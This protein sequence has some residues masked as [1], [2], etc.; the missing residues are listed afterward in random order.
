MILMSAMLAAGS[1]LPVLREREPPNELP[2]RVDC[3]V[4]EGWKP[5]EGPGFE[6]PVRSMVFV[7]PSRFFGVGQKKA[8][9][10]VTE[11]R[12]LSDFEEAS[13]DLIDWQKWPGFKASIHFGETWLTIDSDPSQRGRIKLKG[14]SIW[15]HASPSEWTG[16]CQ[17]VPEIPDGVAKKG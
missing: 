13:L 14:F 5:G 7:F 17:F 3:L 9:I 12:G 10:T 4:K 16:E 15:D 11:D 8:W 2:N 6:L 1:P